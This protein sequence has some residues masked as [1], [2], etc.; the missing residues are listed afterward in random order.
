[1][2][3]DQPQ[4][5]HEYGAQAALPMWMEFIEAA[6]KGKQEVPLE[7][8]PGIVN[9]RIDTDTGQRANANNHNAMFEYFML[10]YLPGEEP[11]PE[12]N[13]ITD[14]GSQILDELY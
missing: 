8:P 6:L 1:M 10:P 3:F 14:S 13:P 9:I 12:D 5:L 7:Q 4:S 11:L 2:G